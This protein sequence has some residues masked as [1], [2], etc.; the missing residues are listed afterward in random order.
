[1]YCNTPKCVPWPVKHT[2]I[3]IQCLQKTFQL[4]HTSLGSVDIQEPRQILVQSSEEG[5]RCKA[6]KFCFNLWALKNKKQAE[7]LAVNSIALIYNCSLH[8]SRH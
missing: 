6:S 3:T 5:Y 2:Y 8:D 4:L 7:G 1:M